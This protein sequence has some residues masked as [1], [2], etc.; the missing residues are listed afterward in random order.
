M[1][2]LLAI[3]E[4]ALFD[5]FQFGAASIVIIFAFFGLRLLAKVVES[6]IRQSKGSAWN[7]DSGSFKAIKELSKQ[8]ERICNGGLSRDDRAA[9]RRMAPV[10]ESI[11]SHLYKSDELHRQLA[12]ELR[13]HR[14]TE[15]RR[16][17]LE[18]ENTKRWID[19][20]ARIEGVARGFDEMLARGIVCQYGDT[21]IAKK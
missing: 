13:R 12:E 8:V 16:M 7:G 2:Q 18:E 15:E 4:A 9:L 20:Y 5:P 1:N 19:A 11:D 6:Y 17:A 14:E 3:G 21:E 10:L